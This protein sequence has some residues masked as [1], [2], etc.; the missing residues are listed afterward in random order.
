[1]NVLGC[2]DDLGRAV[3]ETARVIE[4]GGRFCLSIPHPFHTAAGAYFEE[5][6]H[7]ESVHGVEFANVH[8]PLET[9]ARALAGAGFAIEELREPPPVFLQLRARKR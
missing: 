7:V 6:R 4:A 9:Y 3:S 1:M 2:V 5:H 8:R